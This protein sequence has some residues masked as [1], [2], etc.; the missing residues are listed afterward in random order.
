MSHPTDEIVRRGEPDF[1]DAY[2]SGIWLYVIQTLGPNLVREGFLEEGVR[3]CV[4]R[5]L[6][7]VCSADAAS[8]EPFDVDSG[9][10]DTFLKARSGAPARRGLGRALCR[11]L[12]L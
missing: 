4:A 3:R 10:K 11:T 5:G 8:P 6:R 2:A 9:R 1:F 12:H 7:H